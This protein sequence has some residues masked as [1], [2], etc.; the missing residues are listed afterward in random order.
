VLSG[1]ICCWAAAWP[2]AAV[3]SAAEA[4][5][6]IHLVVIVFPPA[7]ALDPDNHEL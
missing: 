2:A 7:L 1:P 3:K 6:S 5:A 4:A